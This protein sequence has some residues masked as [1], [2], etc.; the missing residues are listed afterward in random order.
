MTWKWSCSIL[1][2]ET[3][4]H[5]AVYSECSPF[6]SQNNMDVPHL[7]TPQGLDNAHSMKEYVCRFG[8][9]SRKIRI[10]NH[11]TTLFPI[12]GQIC[13]FE[14][15][16]G[17][18]RVHLALYQSL[19]PRITPPPEAYDITL[20]SMCLSINLIFFFFCAVRLLPKLSRQLVLLRTSCLFS[21]RGWDEP[22]M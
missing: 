10:I 8:R 9:K 5:K 20:L 21:G 22:I 14:K 13:Y 4:K 11:G 19:C 7:H 17:G 1:Y 6:H 2:L 16:N 12:L 18:L 15:I 3:S